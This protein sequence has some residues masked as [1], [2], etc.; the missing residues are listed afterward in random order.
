MIDV[1]DQDF[2]EQVVEKSHE[3]PVVVDLWAPWCGPCKTLGPILD[4]VIGE[5]D[6]KVVGVKINVDEN[7][8]VSQAFQVQS[9]PMVVAF[10]DGQAVDGFMGAQGEPM[11]RDFVSKLLPTEEENQ[12]ESL[13]AAGDETSL[14]AALELDNDHEGA[15]VALAELL[16]GEDRAEE[17][18]QLL[19]RIPETAETGSLH[20]GALA[21]ASATS[22]SR[23]WRTWR[24]RRPWRSTEGWPRAR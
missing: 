8:A 6:G 3:V 22:R 2:N 1:T 14:R 18:L 10:K 9:I 23:G 12:V 24:R 17:R 7:P 15:I 11:V 21:G 20:G 4:T 13:V 16:V 5:Q 19:E